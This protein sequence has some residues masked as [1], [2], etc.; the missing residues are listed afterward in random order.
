MLA[1]LAVLALLSL[2]GPPTG[3]TSLEQAPPL[4]AAPPVP[5][6]PAGSGEAQVTI[7]LKKLDAIEPLVREAIAE[8]KLPG[9]VVPAPLILIVPWLTVML[10]LPGPARTSVPVPVLVTPPVTS[11]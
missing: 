3:Q 9:A 6:G 11:L 8:K 2:S 7:D 10:A 1:I 5:S 4:P